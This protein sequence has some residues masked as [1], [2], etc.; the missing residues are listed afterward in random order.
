MA[1]TDETPRPRP[2]PGRL[3]WLAG[4]ALGLVAGAVVAFELAGISH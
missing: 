2:H 4:L 1:N 3:V